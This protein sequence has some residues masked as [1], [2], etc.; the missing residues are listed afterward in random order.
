MDSTAWSRSARLSRAYQ[1]LTKH[2]LNKLDD[3]MSI[4]YTKTK[5]MDF[6]IYVIAPTRFRVSSL[7]AGIGSAAM[8]GC[9]VL[10][11]PAV[12]GFVVII[13]TWCLLVVIDITAFILDWHKATSA[14]RNILYKEK[15][16]THGRE[17]WI[18]RTQHHQL[19]S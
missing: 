12:V 8:L 10:Y 19:T 6:D 3:R 4:L 11:H 7:L 14:R 2:Y 16:G 1:A 18:Q 17:V 15:T 13:A 5:S 9:S